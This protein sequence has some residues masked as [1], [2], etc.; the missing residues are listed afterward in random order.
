[1]GAWRL[2]REALEALE[3]VA[4]SL[5]PEDREALWSDPR[6]ARLRRTK[7]GS[8]DDQA[9]SV[10]AEG[11]STLRLLDLL[12]RLASEHDLERL[13]ERITDASVEISG[14]ERGLVL[15][16][17]D[18]GELVTR[19]DRGADPTQED[20]HTTF[21]RSIAESV[22][23]DGLPLVTVDAQDDARVQEY[24]SVHRLMLKSIAC[25][26]IVGRS[27]TVGVLY[28]EH[29]RR[30]GRFRESDMDV[31]VAFADQAAIAIE[32]A[33]LVASNEERQRQL[34]ASN[35]AL[36]RAKDELER[37]LLDRTDELVSARTEIQQ[38][39]DHLGSSEFQG[40]VGRSASMRQVFALVER[41]GPASVPVVIHG[42]SGTGKELVARAIHAMS[43]RSEG[44]FIALNCAAVPENLIESEL[45]GHVKGAFTGADRDRRG[46]MS[47]ASGGTLFLD[48]VGDMPLKMQV[49]L[50][51]VLQDGRVR[52]V[53][54]TK[55]EV[56]DVRIV[57]ASNKSLPELVRKKAFR[58]DLFY[59]L[60]V[61]KIDLQPLRDRQG[62]VPLLASF[63]MR[64]VARDAGV[65]PKQLDRAAIER[66]E[67]HSWPGNVRQLEHV[68]LG[69]TVMT[70]GNMIG[71][72]DL[73]LESAEPSRPVTEPPKDE[74]EHKDDEKQRILRTLEQV[75]WNRAKA[76]KVLGIPR[77]T[78]YR[79]LKEYEIL[80]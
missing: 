3:T 20:P 71:A 1:D 35:A 80:G 32:N 25:L 17:D 55:D 14:A 49:D 2:E 40:I 61:V 79:R 19:A 7:R 29:R 56:V 6:K 41:V 76:A 65:A 43:P 11:R 42:E 62:D 5:S 31:L 59:R 21:S 18:G 23:I 4:L 68:L 57:C 48:E 28:L 38:I 39:R 10:S 44:P 77:R 70:Q 53:G 66:L 12:K 69:A 46:V 74:S 13:L 33:R 78:F 22:L 36:E 60:N 27:G 9:V 45:F 51:R 15:I 34:E 16:V 75:G 50:L 24:L 8:T 54:G 26:P 64:K 37:L 47:L 30:T 63:L 72:A 67:L 58:E 73:T 52:P